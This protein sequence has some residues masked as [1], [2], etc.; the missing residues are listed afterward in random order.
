MKSNS[1]SLSPENDVDPSF[2]STS[3]VDPSQHSSVKMA[4]GTGDDKGGG[5]REL[6]STGAAGTDDKL[7]STVA[8]GD[9]LGEL[10]STAVVAGVKEPVPA[11]SNTKELTSTVAGV[12]MDSVGGV[13]SMSR[14]TI[15]YIVS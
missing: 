7:V 14:V 2:S 3:S 12:I 4:G 9:V 6:E 10:P 8:A 5:A 11:C 15:H 1:S 13:G